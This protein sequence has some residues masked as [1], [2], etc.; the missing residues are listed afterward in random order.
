MAFLF[1]SK[2]NQQASGLPPATRN[3]HTSEGAPTV[4]SPAAPNGA[5]EQSG[6]ISQT[7]T[8]SSSYNNSLNSVNSTNSPEHQRARP[9][10]ESESQAQRPPQAANTTS[11]NSSPGASLYPWSQRRLNFSTPQGNPFPRYGAAINAVASKE[12]DIYMM[13]GLIDG[14]TVKGDLWMVESSGGN[15]SCFPVATVSEGPGPRVGHA[16]LLVGNAFIVFGGDTK[17]D[18]SDDL[19]DTLYLLNTS[20]RQWSRAIPPNPRPAGRYGHTIN[21]LGSKLYV[22]GGQVEGY[23]FND[24]VAFDLN[25]LQNPANKWEFLIRNSHEGGP[26]PGQIP[27]A[28]TNHTMVSFND[29]LYLFGGTN[30]LQWFNDVWSYDP[31]ANQW[32]QLDCVGFIPTPREGHAAALV[33]DVMYIFGGRTDEGI[34]LGDLAAFRITTRR[35]YSFQNMG[36]APSPRSGHSMT[37]FGKQII[38]LAG[39]PSSAPRDPVE[40]SMTY[41]LDTTKIRYPTET[42]NGEKVGASSLAMRKGSHDRHGAPTGRT[43][44]EAQN[45]PPA[46][47]QQRRGPGQ[48]RESMMVT[49]NSR[50]GDHGPGAGPGSRLPRASIAQ[51]PAGPPPPGQAPTP[52]PRGSTPQHAMNPRSKTP[53]DR[54]YGGPTA[55]TVRAMASERDRESPVARDSS[56]DPRSANDPGPMS[57]GHRTPTQTPS[58]MSARAMEAGEAAPLARQRSLRQHRQRGS[59]DS[60]DESVLGRHASIDGSI[61]S[62]GHRNS[63]SMGDE[64]RSPRLTAH[65]EALIKELEAAKNRNAWYASELALAKK[66]GYTVNFSSNAIADERAA[67]MFAD[68]DRPLIEAFLAMRAEL[69]K[70]QA[71]VDRQAAIAS[72]RVAEVEHQRDVAVNEAAYSRA[73]LAAHGGSQRGTPQPDGG[74]QDPDEAIADRSTE[75]GRRLAMALASQN[76][77]KSKLEAVSAEL[78]Q[79]KRGRELAEETCEATRRRLAELEMQNNTLEVESLR[80]EFHRVEA[81]AREE[82]LLRSEAEASLK[83]LTL[84]KEELLKRLEDSSSRLRDFG[85]NLGSLREA[86]TASSEKTALLERQLE[87]ERELREGLERKLLQLR[88][89]H[90]ERAAELENATRRLRDAE[91]LAESNAREAET[92]KNAFLAGLERASSF[93]SETSIRS[94]ADQRVAALEAQVERANKLAKVNQAA[95]DE[96]ADKLRRAEERIAGLEA[97]QEQASREGLQLR[98]QLQAVMKESQAHAAE[99]RELKSKLENQHREAGAL[100]IQHATLKDLLAERGVSYTDSRRSPRLESPGSRFGTPEQSR[101]RELEQQLSASLKAHEELKASFETR[102][103]EAD[104]AYRE[105]LEQL[106]NDYQS[107]VHYVKGTE[108]MLKRMKDELTR[109]KAQNAKIQAD[110]E[111]AQRSISQASGQGS[112]PPVEWETE[113]SKLQQSIS[114]LQQDTASSIANLEIQIAKL[115]EDLSAAE[116]EKDK[117]RSEYESVKQELIAAAEKNRAELEQLKQENAL[118]EARASDA[119]Q[120]VAMLLDQVEASVGHYRRQSQPVQG[121]NGISRTHSNASSNTISGVSGRPRADSAVSQDDPFPDN[122]G[123]MALDSLANELEALRSHWE[124]TNRNYRLSTQSDFD[125]TPTKETHGLSDSLAEWR[126]KLDEEESRA[127]SPEKNKP[128]AVEEQAA[129]NMI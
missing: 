45:T 75:M 18:E 40:L 108:K 102:E 110:L 43:S 122:R 90:E 55:D 125:R 8:P 28:R 104:R 58:R 96:A 115:K 33:N 56:K 95:A 22:F 103:Q 105:K 54:N 84:D 81:T 29:K 127:G 48:T 3:V 24:L 27:P 67:D 92:H 39:E 44:R 26:S 91:E 88:S 19:D 23:F 86:V 14:S 126:R 31:R 17:V 129:A 83:Q 5:K 100:A 87:E 41:I 97:Y 64:P 111:A 4:T 71:T 73:K 46:D 47:S 35:W 66:A 53:T 118:L 52:G 32:S 25:Q 20:S 65:Q 15:L 114:D 59:M 49:P 11:P 128:R 38:V 36:P 21:I 7:P 50:P 109:Y 62:R 10:A 99:N 70:M 124:S 101:L 89:E 78:D 106:E 34:D 61:E 37:A 76:E 123:S 116:A 79:E 74:S 93:D 98:R 80:A 72:K 63:K 1:K 117:S 113:R 42:Q 82:S 57:S 6:G 120:K 69:A 107:A 77:L 9:R 51:A 94:M 2:K 13:G 30:G 121:M 16:S 85:N 119:D 60:A 112:E 68:E 12:G